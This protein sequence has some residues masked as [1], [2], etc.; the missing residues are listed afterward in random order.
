MAKKKAAKKPADDW[1]DEEREDLLKLANDVIGRAI[2]ER[3]AGPS[4]R[5][6]GAKTS[7]GIW[8]SLLAVIL[9]M[10][11][12]AFK[13]CNKGPAAKK[14]AQIDDEARRLAN[15]RRQKRQERKAH[16]FAEKVLT[17]QKVIDANDGEELTDEEKDDLYEEAVQFAFE[18]RDSIAKS[19]ATR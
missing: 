2:A 19:A 3:R 14:A 18:N 9:P 6:S 8:D 16:K 10:L 13:N 5:T 17:S 11:L 1:T 15:H 12:D 7:G 4:S